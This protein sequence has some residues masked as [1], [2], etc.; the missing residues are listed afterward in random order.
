MEA[1]AKDPLKEFLRFWLASRPINTAIDYPTSQHGAGTGTVLYR[2]D[3]YQVQLFVLK[4]NSI[5]EPHIHPNVDSYEVYV[6][7]DA[8]LMR[9]GRYFEPKEYGAFIRV[10]P[11]T[12]HGGEF[13]PRGCS[14]LSVQRWLNGVSPTT[15]GDDWHDAKGN[16]S[17]AG[18]NIKQIVTETGEYEN[19]S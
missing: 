2:K 7:G 16:T 8:K 13:G 10:K 5:I 4:P 18:N 19:N 1:E 6:N 17:G 14:F 11:S 15:I 3:E 12:W 9:E